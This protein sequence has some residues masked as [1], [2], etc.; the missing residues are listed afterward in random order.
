LFALLVYF[1]SITKLKAIEGKMMKSW[2]SD[3][4]KRFNR[5]QRFVTWFIGGVLVLILCIWVGG[6]VLAYKAVTVAG[7]QD[8]S[9]GIKPVIERLWCGKPGCFGD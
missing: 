1:W 7:E 2:N 5:M 3:F 4:D 9:G 8:W 6:A